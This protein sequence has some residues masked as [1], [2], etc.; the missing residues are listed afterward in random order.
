MKKSLLFIP[1]AA[2]ILS[3]GFIFTACDDDDDKDLDYPETYVTASDWTFS[4]GEH[5]EICIGEIKTRS[6]NPQLDY[7]VTSEYVDVAISKVPGKD[8]GFNVY[9]VL[10]SLDKRVVP[11][12]LESKVLVEAVGGTNER[13]SKEVDINQYGYLAPVSAEKL[14]GKYSLVR[15]NE[16]DADDGDSESLTNVKSNLQFN[17]DGTLIV[18]NTAGIDEL[19][20]GTFSYLLNEN[21]LS[22]GYP[23]G[24][25]SIISLDENV[26]ILE[27]IEMDGLRIDDYKQFIFTRTE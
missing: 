21:T 23:E 19:H 14:A 17:A 3:S 1:A 25:F 10:V 8:D 6:D 4:P 5:N 12:M 11:S 16:L 13:V 26:L 18:N 22:L 7:N 20:N 15:Y 9:K 24:R 2:M 27:Q